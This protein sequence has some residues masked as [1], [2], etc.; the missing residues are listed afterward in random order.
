MFSGRAVF[1][2]EEITVTI[3]TDTV[4]VTTA[5]GFFIAG[6]QTVTIS[7]TNPS[8]YN[9]F[10]TTLG[11]GTAL[12]DQNNNAH[13]IPTFTLPSGASSLPA[14]NTGY[15]YG[16]S[17]DS[18]ANYFPVPDPSGEGDRIF[19]NDTS[20]T[21]THSL[22]FGLKPPTNTHAGVY[23]KDF[24]ITVV[25]SGII[26]CSPDTIC[27]HGN[28]DDGTGTMEDQAVTSNTNTML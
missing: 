8:G 21:N 25:A 9:G 15:G 16:Y 10:L 22:T 4:D 24:A 20:G 1:A 3:S 14:G 27:Y 26:P 2:A 12:V 17:I 28:G 6:S 7:T 23:R 13:T 11:T 18:G 5:P 19:S